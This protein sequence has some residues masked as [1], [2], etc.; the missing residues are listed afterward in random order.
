MEM[1]GNWNILGHEWAVDLLQKNLANQRL[2]HAY[3]FCGPPGVGR[4]TLA[5]KLA[6]SINCEQREQASE[7]CGR[8]L[9]CRQIEKMQHP[10]LTV[11]QAEQVGGNLKVQQIRE[12][13]H[14]LSLS[15]YAGRYRVA[16]IL[17]FEEANPNAANALL[18]TLEEPPKRVVLMLTATEPE[19]LL[20]TIVSRCEIIRLRSLPLETVSTGLQKHFDVSEEQAELLAHLS[21]GR[22]G[23]SIQ[24]LQDP[25]LLLK[26][27]SYL[28]DLGHLLTSHR[29]ERFAYADQLSKGKDNIGDIMQTWATF[30]RDVLLVQS[31]S[32]VPITNLDRIDEIHKIARYVDIQKA[33]ALIARIDRTQYL[34]SR[35]VNKTLTL[36]VLLLNF[37][38]LPVSSG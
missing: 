25:D 28:E 1:D 29:V 31:G 37:P 3:L 11:V 23:L 4:R 36:E 20:P 8:C 14:S 33:K 24:Y 13:Q 35:N 19:R 10:D 16:L 9:S 17:R 32:N 18:K 5:L 15:P 34:L 6:Q 21:G 12:M 7:P 27:Q 2:R 22:P 26:R 30:W 38:F